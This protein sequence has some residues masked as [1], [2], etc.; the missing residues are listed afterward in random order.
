MLV[1]FNQLPDESRVWIYQANRSFSE[2]ELKEIK[3]KLE[4]FITSWTAHGKDLQSGFKMLASHR[5]TF[6]GKP[7]ILLTFATPS[8]YKSDYRCALSLSL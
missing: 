7:T 3:S 6:L 5:W 8:V 1:D 2:D 4:T